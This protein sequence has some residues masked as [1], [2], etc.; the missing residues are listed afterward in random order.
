MKKTLL[1][2][3][4]CFL[5]FIS[6]IGRYRPVSLDLV[7]PS[8]ME[9]EIK[10][11][12]QKPGVYRVKWKANVKEIINA[13][14]G[15]NDNADLSGISLVRTCKP[16]D[17]IVIPEQEIVPIKKVSINTATL[18]QLITLPR[19]GPSTAERII[20]YREQQPFQTLEDIM[21]VKGI[22]PKMF[23]NIKDLICL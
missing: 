16:N 2:F 22:G 7:Q 21:Q 18:E 6:T 5:I 12:V 14:G 15:K 20:A 17:V 8:T 23:E 3:C 13:A 19:V 11:A 4:A 10:G 9:V 1:F